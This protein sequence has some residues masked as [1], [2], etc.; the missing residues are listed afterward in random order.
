LERAVGGV[1]NMDETAKL[2]RYR[3]VTGQKFRGL[4]PHICEVST[5]FEPRGCLWAPIWARWEKV[6]E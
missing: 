5:P 6:G 1:K 3:C 4:C 2:R